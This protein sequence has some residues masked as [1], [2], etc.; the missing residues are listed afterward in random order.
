MNQELFT[1][2]RAEKLLPKVK[3]LLRKAMFLNS[4]LQSLR[5]ELVL[6]EE[7]IQVETEDQNIRYKFELVKDHDLLNQLTEDFYESLEAIQKLGCHVKDVE[8]GLIDF[9][10]E[11]EGRTVFLCWKLGEDRIQF[12]HELDTGFKDR[13]KIV[14]L[15]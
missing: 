4:Q 6:G 9:P 5:S 8:Q 13:Q 3:G 2:S 1:I 15:S 14:E 12:W 11:F 10:A 7:E